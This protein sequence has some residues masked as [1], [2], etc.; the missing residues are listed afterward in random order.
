MLE[1][2][3]GPDYI[4]AMSIRRWIHRLSGGRL[5]PPR[6]VVAVLRLEGI[7]AARGG[8]GQRSLSLP[9]LAEQIERAF[10]LDGLVGVALAIN[11][12]GGS[13]AQSAL[14]QG[15]IRQFA[16]EKNIPVLAF[17]E[18]VAASGGYWL[19]L[20]GDEI[21]ATEGSIVGSIGVISAGFGFTDVLKRLG[22]Q[23]RVYKAGDNKAM[24]DPFSPEDPDDIARLKVLQIDIHD[25]FKAIVRLRRGARLK[26]TPELFSGAIF[27]GRQAL[28]HGL[29]DGIGEMRAVLRERF[30]DKIRLTPVVARGGS[31]WLRRRLPGIAGR[32]LPVDIALDL[33]DAVEER[34]VWA[35]FGL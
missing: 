17:A 24:L 31:F 5:L 13:P 16:V 14:I 6:P 35:R 1:F 11:S 8:A 32:S 28:T 20:A 29:I 19:A 22:I 10:G 34:A 30:G 23:R 3:R 9:G 12:P 4:P 26:E 2:L 15:R 18:D 33:L 27:T 25:G 7:I 21:F